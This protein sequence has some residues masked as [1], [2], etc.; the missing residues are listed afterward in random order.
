MANSFYL[1]ASALAKRYIPENGSLHVHA[2]LDRVPGNRLYL[3]NVGVGEVASVFIRTRNAGII[4][5]ACFAQ[6]LTEFKREII[7]AA[8]VTKQS[9]TNRLAFSSL[10]LLEAHAISSTDA[11]LLKSAL[12]VARK[13][14]LGGNDLVLVASD[15][16]LLRAAQAEGLST[17]NP[18][19]QD[20]GPGRLSEPL[21]RPRLAS[22]FHL[23]P[24]RSP[25]AAAYQAYTSPGAPAGQ[26]RL[27]SSLPSADR[28]TC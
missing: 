5:A 3:L 24:G 7:H 2:L 18:E 22:S 6:A 23:S 16:R 13:L 10:A 25:S 19:S 4:S 21:N 27:T 11:L 17:F 26:H 9:V 12:T 14:R 1:D 28:A 8:D 15:Q 20:H